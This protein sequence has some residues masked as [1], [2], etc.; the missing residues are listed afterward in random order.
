MENFLHSFGVD[1]LRLLWFGI[2]FGVVLYLLRRYAFGPILRAID[3]RQA[4]INR[5]L[6]DAELAARSVEENR[7]K[8]E[9]VLTDASVQA[10]EMMRRAEKT[11]AE[12]HDQARADARAEAVRI[13]EKARAEIERERAAAV[14]DI[15]RQAVDLALAAA[16]RVIERNLD[17]DVNRRLAEETIK[18]ADLRA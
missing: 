5:S 18:Q 7:Q 13:V 4:G 14:A 15:R 2:L 9:Q 3:E 11:G 1:W 6:D 8:A 17:A 12:L 16:G 10:Q